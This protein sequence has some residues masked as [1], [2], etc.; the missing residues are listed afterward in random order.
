MLQVANERLQIAR[1]S[2]NMGGPGV[3]GVDHVS[4]GQVRAAYK[5]I[6]KGREVGA[7]GVA[8]AFVITITA[9]LTFMKELNV[10]YGFKMTV[11]EHVRCYHHVICIVPQQGRVQ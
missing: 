3:I 6:R 4:K 10:V 9:V 1:V 7:A 2:L 5:S 11:E 8:S